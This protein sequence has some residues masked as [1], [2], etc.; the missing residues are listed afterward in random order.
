[1]L[2]QSSFYTGFFKNKKVPRNCFHALSFEKFF[3]K[4]FFC[5]ITYTGQISIPECAYFP[6]YS[7][8]RL[9]S[10]LDI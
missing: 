6:S 5:N 9:I 7:V 2:T 1:M 8:K 4:F 10:C 3:D